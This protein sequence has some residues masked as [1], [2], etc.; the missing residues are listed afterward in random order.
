MDRQELEKTH[1]LYNKMESFWQFMG[2]AYDGIDALIEIKAIEKHERESKDNYNARI[3]ELFAFNYSKS[4]IDIF[5]HY[6]HEKPPKRELAGL[7]ED[8]SWLEFMDDCD[9]YGTKWDTF[10]SD[11]QKNASIY[12]FVGILIDKAGEQ[13]ETR[14]DELAL[15]IYPYAVAYMPQSILD[16][17]YDREPETNRP[18]LSYLKVQDD[19]GQYRIWTPSDWE[20]WRIN[21]DTGKPEIVKAG[22]NP[23]GEIPFVFFQNIKNRTRRNIGISDIAGIA[24][25]DASI[26]RNLSHGEEVIK[27]SAFPMMRKP[28]VAAGT[29]TDTVGVTSVLE[30]DPMLPD[31]KPDWLTAPVAEPIN[32]ILEWIAKKVEEIYRSSNTGGLHFTEVSS[33]AKSG[34][35]LKQEFQLLNAV[36][37]HKADNEDE[38]E[39]YCLYHWLS[40]QGNRDLYEDIE[41]KRPRDFSIA[42]MTA[43]LAN[44]L[45]AKSLVASDLFKKA[46]QKRIARNMLEGAPE[47]D[48]AA[49]DEEID[50]EKTEEMATPDFTDYSQA[51]QQG[52]AGDNKNSEVGNNNENNNDNR[53]QEGEQ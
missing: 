45:T 32:S 21:Q 28:M 39:L 16:W 34:V 27:Y 5:S 23:L 36:L 47:E 10:L 22:F 44:A 14:A 51:G 6:L 31:S 12:G 11:Q 49:I 13:M 25:I 19:D 20:V 3:K 37:S 29:E 46:L 35:A 48:L 53:G 4:V 9:L 2:A 7:A 52:P 17:E 18:F 43:D 15:G 1:A 40:W 33:N 24:R 41:I 38:A 30:F 50:A 42:D 26:I 8:T